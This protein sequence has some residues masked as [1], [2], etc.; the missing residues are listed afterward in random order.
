M[1]TINSTT[2]ESA[3][4]FVITNPVTGE[5]EGEGETYEV[6]AAAAA[7]NN[8][9]RDKPWSEQENAAADR[10]MALGKKFT[11]LDVYADAIVPE[12]DQADWK[13]YQM[14]R[15]ES[16]KLK[17]LTE[18]RFSLITK[19]GVQMPLEEQDMKDLKELDKKWTRVNT[20]VEQK[21]LKATEVK[22]SEPGEVPVI[23]DMPAD[24]LPGDHGMPTFKSPFEKPDLP[25]GIQVDTGQMPE[26]SAG[27]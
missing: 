1:I 3:G 2:P 9:E 7:A 13:E 17:A 10:Y 18:K 8:P 5:V 23:N 12:A 16:D 27:K 20:I 19:D 15:Q 6:A 26:K 24:I 22:P 25:G 14:W 21:T 4:G 11:N